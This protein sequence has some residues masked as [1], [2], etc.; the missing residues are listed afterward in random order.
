MADRSEKKPLTLEDIVAAYEVMRA[1]EL[2][3]QNSSPMR[4]PGYGMFAPRGEHGA[5]ST[6]ESGAYLGSANPHNE[7]D[8]F[9]ARQMELLMNRPAY[10]NPFMTA[11]LYEKA[12]P[13]ISHIRRYGGNE[14]YARQWGPNLGYDGMFL[15]RG[16]A[17]TPEEQAAE[18]YRA[19]IGRFQPRT[20]KGGY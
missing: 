3:S 17:W 18:N 10:G 16:D 5:F 8:A 4:R 9:R 13:P 6:N 19:Y 12:H 7:A 20:Y 14:A 15:G 1:R 2:A 11:E